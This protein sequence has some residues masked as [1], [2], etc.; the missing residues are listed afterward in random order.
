[1]DGYA[2]EIY[3]EM[4]N[5]LV[6][7]K[8]SGELSGL[9]PGARHQLR[10]PQAGHF[11][12]DYR[13]VDYD[14]TDENWKE[15]YYVTSSDGDVVEFLASQGIVKSGANGY[16]IVE[17]RTRKPG[18]YTACFTRISPSLIPISSDFDVHDLQTRTKAERISY[19]VGYYNGSL[20]TSLTVDSGLGQTL[21]IVNKEELY[22]KI[23]R[24][25]TEV[26]PI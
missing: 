12:E 4:Q 24:W 8:A 25:I 22:L 5:R 3:V 16:Y 23:S 19:M 17:L 7:M 10:G 20:D 14:G 2:R 26:F 6:A 9:S 11:G 18:M 15:L 1:M 13:P 21:T